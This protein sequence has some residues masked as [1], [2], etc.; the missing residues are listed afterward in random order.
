ML[1]MFRPQD[2]KDKSLSNIKAMRI[3]RFDIA[4]DTF[5]LLSACE[6]TK[7][8]WDRLKELYSS[9]AD[10]KHSVQTLLL[11][12]FGAFV[13]KF[14]EKLDKTFNHFNHLLSRMLKHNLKRVKIEQKL[15]FMNRLRP[16]CKAIVST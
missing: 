3:I 2:E 11:L 4:P 14:D 9:D 1:N 7:E 12:E 16:E 15:T 8:I 13:Q 6:T 10:L 5:H